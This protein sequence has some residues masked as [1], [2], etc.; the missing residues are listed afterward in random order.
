MDFSLLPDGFFDA[1]RWIFLW[2]QSKIS[3]Q[4]QARVAELRSTDVEIFGA[5]DDNGAAVHAFILGGVG[6]R[7]N[8]GSGRRAQ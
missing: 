7:P 2:G 6:F 1:A 3:L 8:M 4:A 5:L